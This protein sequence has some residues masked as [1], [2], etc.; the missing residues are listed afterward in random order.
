MDRLYSLMGCSGLLRIPSEYDFPIGVERQ[1]SLP[2]VTCPQLSGHHA[3]SVMPI[4]LG[5]MSGMAPN[6]LIHK[7]LPTAHNESLRSM[8]SCQTPD[9]TSWECF[10]SKHDVMS[11]KK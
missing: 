7:N 10:L 4:N 11:L 8:S 2:S 9:S 1:R 3:S 6:P 5:Y